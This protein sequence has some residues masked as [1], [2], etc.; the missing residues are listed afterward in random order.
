MQKETEEYAAR[1]DLVIASTELCNQRYE[2][3][4]LESRVIEL[5]EKLSARSILL[6]LVL[7]VLMFLLGLHASGRWC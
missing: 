3:T 5:Q 7:T 6:V 4:K 2:N 1:R